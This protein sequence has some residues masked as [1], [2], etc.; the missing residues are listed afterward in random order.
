MPLELI[1]GGQLL[2]AL[3][4]QAVLDHRPRPAPAIW[5]T[6]ALPSAGLWIA[7]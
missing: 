4:A 7:P 1:D 6:S 2:D 3:A 5:L